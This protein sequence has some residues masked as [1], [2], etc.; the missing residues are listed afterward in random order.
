[1]TRLMRLL[2]LNE[3]LLSEM[4]HYREDAAEFSKNV[5]GQRRLLRSLMNVR[6]AGDI[7][8]EFLREQDILLQEEATEKGIVRVSSL[9]TVADDSQGN[10]LPHGMPANRMILWQGDI[11]RLATDGIVNA[12]NSALL[13]CF[14]P[15]HGCIDNAIHSAA[16]V[17]LRNACDHLMKEQGHT[18]PTG[19]AK[20]TPAFNLPSRYVLHTVGPIIPAGRNPTAKEAA[21]LSDCYRSCLELA[22]K[23]QLQSLAFCCISTGEFHF[24]GEQAAQIAVQT[25][26]DW[27]TQRNSA[28]TVV[29][30]VFKDEDAEVYRK[31][32]GM[33]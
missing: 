24:P 25:V 12:A 23:H 22:A 27:L 31:V 4:P 21:L 16:G 19:E 28:L 20:I 29:F 30:D 5:N 33:K 7:G 18:E 1:M 9:P 17:Q 15:C 32:L 8:Q 3:I 6:P 10:A 26:S 13:G 14:A 11:T 2:F